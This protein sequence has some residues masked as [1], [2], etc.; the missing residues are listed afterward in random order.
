VKLEL[1][2]DASLPTLAWS[3][4]WDSELFGGTTR[5]PAT[6]PL[7]WVLLPSRGYRIPTVPFGG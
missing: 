1:T 7:D 2:R 4:C 3:G 5:L 6:R